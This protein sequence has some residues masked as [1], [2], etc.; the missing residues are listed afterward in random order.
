MRRRQY[1]GVYAYDADGS[2]LYRATFRDSAGRKRQKRGFSSPTAAAKY[3]AKMMERAE[4]GELRTTRQRFDA[5][6]RTAVVSVPEGN[7]ST[8]VRRAGASGRSA[9]TRPWRR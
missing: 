8:A 3:R 1:P 4:R 2:T 6:N 7:T 5:F 9:T